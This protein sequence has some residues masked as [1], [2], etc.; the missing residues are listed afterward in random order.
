[1][2]QVK[3]RLDVVEEGVDIRR[4]KKVKKLSKLSKSMNSKPKQSKSKSYGF[5]DP[6]LSSNSE[7]LHLFVNAKVLKNGSAIG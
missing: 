3:D 2:C 6:D 1:M 4:H 5:T 7:Q